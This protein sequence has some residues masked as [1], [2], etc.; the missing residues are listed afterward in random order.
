MLNTN[1][2]VGDSQNHPKQFIMNKYS[3]TIA[4]LFQQRNI[5]AMNL[6][7]K[8]L[9]VSN[10]I[11]LTLILA[12]ASNLQ[13][14]VGIASGSITPDASSMLEV[15]S[16]TK[17]LLT[18]RMTTSQKNAISNPATGLTIY[19]TDSTAG[20]YVYTGSAWTRLLTATVPVVDG[21]TGQSS[22]T[23]GQLLIGNTTGN[24]LTKSTLTAGSGISI[25]N[26]AGSIT[27]TNT[28][29][30]SDSTFTGSDVSLTSANTWF[31]VTG[32]SFYASA[33][34]TY[35]F[36]LTVLF[37]STVSDKGTLFGFNGPGSPTYFAYAGLQPK[38]S[39]TDSDRFG[40]NVYNP[41]TTVGTFNNP[42][43][44]ANIAVIEGIL[45]NGSTAG[46]F[47][48]RAKAEVANT[49]TVLGT[50]STLKVW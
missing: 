32:L 14:Q 29:A 23:N 45:V 50:K 44:G 3:N 4:L 8:M 22:Y 24:T 27:I 33:N 37:N 20:Y 30:A 19:Q 31:N 49:I 25:T 39:G 35:R 47:T 9:S 34:S 11:I 48:L 28:G 21:G 26:G 41:T 17:G 7:K 10:F 38:N 15:Q 16:T 1:S 12:S 43:T 2:I 40:N 6:K 46:T 36:R 13:A 42:F 18:P 5:L